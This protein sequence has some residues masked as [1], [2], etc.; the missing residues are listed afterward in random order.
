MP[1]ALRERA[2]HLK[3][4]LQQKRPS[5]ATQRRAL[6]IMVRFSMIRRPLSRQRKSLRKG[7][8][9]RGAL[10]AS[11][12]AAG[13]IAQI[14][15]LSGK[16]RLCSID[17]TFPSIEPFDPKLALSAR[18]MCHRHDQETSGE[19]K[20]RSLSESTA[21]EKDKSARSNPSLH[22]KALVRSTP[23]DVVLSLKNAVYSEIMF[24]AFRKLGRKEGAEDKGHI[25]KICKELVSA[26]KERMGTSGRFLRVSRKGE[27][28]AT[29]Q[30]GDDEAETSKCSFG[31]VL[32]VQARVRLT[33]CAPSR[34]VEIMMDLK[35][36]NESE[37][38]WS[39]GASLAR[40]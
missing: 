17:C 31:A 23:S 26:M 20:N 29:W 22:D 13:K 19:K 18:G 25:R 35:R 9:R 2:I 12:N 21:D 28:D 38:K 40:E 10:R 16:A 34:A 24:G 27:G 15:L 4:Y 14:L 36:R 5:P 3:T 30:V 8:L 32:P 6:L 37:R 1:I 39:S 33:P 7:I 11:S